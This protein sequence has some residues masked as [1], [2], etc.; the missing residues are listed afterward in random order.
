MS[1]KELL[2]KLKGCPETLDPTV[3]MTSP[4]QIIEIFTG[5]Y[6]L[7]FQ[8]KTVK[9]KGKIQFEWFPNMG[10]Y[11]YGSPISDTKLLKN[12]S[13]TVKVI[14]NDFE[15]GEGFILTTD[16]GTLDGCYGLKG[17]ISKKSVCGDQSIPV[18]KAIFSIANLR[19]FHGIATKRVNE[20]ISVFRN[21][22]VFRS[23]TYE[24]IIDKHPDYKDLK[25][26]LNAKGGYI[27]QY[28][29]QITNQGKP[30]YLDQLNDMLNCFNNFLW[31]LNGRRSSAIFLQGIFDNQVIWTDYTH[32][33]TDIH[34]SVLSWPAKN[35]IKEFDSIW[36]TFCELWKE[37]EDNKSFLRSAIHWYVEANGNAGY[38]EGS[39]IMAQTALE[40]IY[41]WWIVEAKRMISGKDTES[42]SASNKIRLILSQLGISNQIPNS[43]DELR[44][45]ANQ[46]PEITDGP[47]AIVQIRN[48]IVHSQQ[49]KRKKINSI[50]P[51]GKYQSLQLSI[52]Y[53]EM[54]ML[55]ILNYNSLYI[56][57]CSGVVWESEAEH[58]VPW[59]TIEE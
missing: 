46:Y 50:E 28:A 10:T 29:G 21:R 38:V 37:N 33:S 14:V 12:I 11:F 5:E 57:R 58:L 45:F 17:T 55:K 41:N 36:N 22:I 3:N 13:D 31:F 39:I 54:A 26:K 44:S 6:L 25:N 15:L 43:F 4:N 8:D 20:K 35:S 18:E 19:E 49:E 24:I 30:L 23:G 1:K 34:K 40:L 7:E 53:I 56:N 48:A 47:E 2:E 42:I 16:T 59:R 27:I 32:Y 9:L 52:W 51:M